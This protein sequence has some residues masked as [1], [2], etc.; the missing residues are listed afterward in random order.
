MTCTIHASGLQLG[1]P[2]KGLAA[3]AVV[4]SKPASMLGSVA[5][6]TDAGPHP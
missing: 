3:G 5:A 1:L 4:V 6:L 2:H